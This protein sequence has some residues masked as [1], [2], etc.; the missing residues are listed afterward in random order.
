[1]Q[2]KDGKIIV[3]RDLLGKIIKWLNLFIRVG[4]RCSNA[5]MIRLMLLFHGLASD[6]FYKLRGTPSRISISL[7]KGGK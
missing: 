2:G 1:V 3:L 6:F 4:D 7:L 5:S